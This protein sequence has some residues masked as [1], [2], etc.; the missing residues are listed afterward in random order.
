MEL[1]APGSDLAAAPGTSERE[2]QGVNVGFVDGQADLGRALGTGNQG[3]DETQTS[4]GRQTSGR[5]E[6]P[7]LNPDPGRVPTGCGPVPSPDGSIDGA[8]PRV[9]TSHDS[10]DQTP[11]VGG[12]RKWPGHHRHLRPL[13]CGRHERL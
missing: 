13:Q 12:A 5:Q 2:R 10:K 6:R 9:W 7:R 1:R 4:E 8:A 3:R 11:T